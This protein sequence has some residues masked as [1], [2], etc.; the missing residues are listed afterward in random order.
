MTTVGKRIS[1]STVVKRALALLQR[2]AARGLDVTPLTSE[3]RR[4]GT[5]D[6]VVRGNANGRLEAGLVCTETYA[7]FIPQRSAVRSDRALVDDVASEQWTPAQPGETVT[8]RIPE[9]APFSYDGEHLKFTWRVAARARRRGLD[10][11]RTRD[12][13]VLP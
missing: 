9:D 10:R 8:L 3:A 7:S 2:G 4:G 1:W 5:V 6:V 13:H 12:L 11:V